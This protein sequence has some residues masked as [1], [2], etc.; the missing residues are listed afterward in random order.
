VDKCPVRVIALGTG[1]QRGIQESISSEASIIPVDF[2]PA[3]AVA[4]IAGMAGPAMRMV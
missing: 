3:L 4:E 2:L 1:L